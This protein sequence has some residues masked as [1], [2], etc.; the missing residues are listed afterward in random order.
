MEVAL[1]QKMHKRPSLEA[2]E[3]GCQ[4]HANFDPNDPENPVRRLR[5]KV[6]RWLIYPQR[7]EKRAAEEKFQRMKLFWLEVSLIQRHFF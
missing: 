2:S 7:L 5:L 3:S 6:K 1:N 4:S